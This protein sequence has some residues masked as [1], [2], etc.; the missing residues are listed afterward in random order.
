MM[1]Q[2]L[3]CEITCSIIQDLIHFSVEL[4]LPVKQFAACRFPE[5]RDHV[6][7]DVSLVA[8][9]VL[10]VHRQDHAG[11]LLAVIVV[12]ASVNRVG[13]PGE[14]AVNRAGDLRTPDIGRSF[15]QGL[16]GI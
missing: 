12:A 5:G 2:F 1:V 10:R 6:V 15:M 16:S 4:L 7:P 8:D 3:K 13:D 11:F 9:P 14:L